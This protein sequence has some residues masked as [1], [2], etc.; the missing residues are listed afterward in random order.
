MRLEEGFTHPLAEGAPSY[1]GGNHSD[2]INDMVDTQKPRSYEYS[3]LCLQLLK[4]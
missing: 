2:I 1:M 4:P 3:M